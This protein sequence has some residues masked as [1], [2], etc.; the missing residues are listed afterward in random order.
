MVFIYLFKGTIRLMVKNQMNL[1][2]IENKGVA[3]NKYYNSKDG[4]TVGHTQS[5]IVRV[6][7]VAKSLSKLGYDT[8]VIAVSDLSNRALNNVISQSDIVIFHRIQASKITWVDYRY[9]QAYLLSQKY[10]KKI[11]FDVDDAIH[12]TFPLMSEIIANRSSMVFVGSHALVNYYKQFS[13]NVWFVPSSVDTKIIKPTPYP[14]N[15]TTVIG[16]HGSCF[17]HLNN[18]LLIS[19]P[20]KKLSKKFDLTFRIIGTA[21]NVQLQGVLA[22]KF[23]GVQ[24]DFGPEYW[25]SYDQ[26][27][28]YMAGVDIGVYP[29]IDNYWNR[30]KCSMK[31]LEY[32]AMKIPS[33]F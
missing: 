24:L 23:K 32:M 28:N 29:L 14:D 1:C 2:F 13:K 21:G 8:Q 27:P 30:A 18:I 6:L 26:L 15:S 7:N 20:L 11:I 25:F 31:L 12:I 5:S 22:K 3:F 19:E 4:T 17:G 10:K 33:C 9:I 16:W